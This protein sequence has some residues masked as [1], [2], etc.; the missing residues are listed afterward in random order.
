MARALTF[1]V[2]GHLL[3][4]AGAGRREVVERGAVVPLPHGEPLLLGLTAV[5]GRSVPLLSVAALLGHGPDAL[6]PG[7]LTLL[8]EEGGE[9]VALAVDSVGEFA[10]VTPVSGDADPLGEAATPGDPRPLHLPALMRLL[11]QQLAPGSRA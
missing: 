2:A 5:H 9:E 1:Q 11:R 7:G 6:T 10:E 8:A 3:S 4:L